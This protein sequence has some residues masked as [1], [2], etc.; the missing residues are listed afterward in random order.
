MR[1]LTKSRSK[2]KA[3]K[4]TKRKVSRRKRNPVINKQL[5]NDIIA[6]ADYLADQ[7]DDLSPSEEEKQHSRMIRY[8]VENILK[9]IIH[10]EEEINDFEDLA[11][12]VYY[13]RRFGTPINS[14]LNKKRYKEWLKQQKYRSWEADSLK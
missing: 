5:I 14:D 11:F 13:Y 1:K 9:D 6:F 10:T 3:K 2:I 12:Q 4:S 8:A 7:H